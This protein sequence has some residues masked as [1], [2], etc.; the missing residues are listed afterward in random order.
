MLGDIWFT[1]WQ[2]APED[3]HLK[4]ELELRQT[5]NADTKGPKRN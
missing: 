3:K 1:A 5:N 4:R 2:E